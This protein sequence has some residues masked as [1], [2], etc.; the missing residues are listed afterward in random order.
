M[1]LIDRPRG[2]IK[3]FIYVKDKTLSKSFCDAVIKKF[4]EDEDYA[5]HHIYSYPSTGERDFKK[6]CAYIYIYIY[7]H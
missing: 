4:D 2:L 7:T 3:D 1:D 6:K 5:Y